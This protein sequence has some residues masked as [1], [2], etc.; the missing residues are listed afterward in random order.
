MFLR[1]SLLRNS[2]KQLRVDRGHR[3]GIEFACWK[4]LEALTYKNRVRTKRNFLIVFHHVVSI[5]ASY[6]YQ[7]TYHAFTYQYG[8]II[9]CNDIQHEY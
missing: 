9:L 8:Y 6:T 2:L 7:R 3:L 5:H 4:M 1:N